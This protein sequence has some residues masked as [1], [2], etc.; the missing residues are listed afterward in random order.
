MDI[1][2]SQKRWGRTVQ[3]VQLSA[4][5]PK[6]AVGAA[7]NGRVFLAG[8]PHFLRSSGS[9]PELSASFGALDDEEFFVIE[10]SR[11]AGTPGVYLAGVL[12]RVAQL[13]HSLMTLT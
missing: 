10:G 3:T 2:V 6:M 12:P 9:V 4:W 5:V 13:N 11:V 8:F 1:P 7:M